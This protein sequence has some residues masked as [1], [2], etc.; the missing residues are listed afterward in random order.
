MNTE[1][2]TQ[3]SPIETQVIGSVK[4]FNNRY[5][6]GFIVATGEHSTYGDVFVHHSELQLSD[7]NVYKFLMPGEYVQFNIAKTVNGKHEFQATGVTGVN[8]GKLMCENQPSTHHRQPRRVDEDLRPRHQP[9]SSKPN[10][11]EQSRESRPPRRPRQESQAPSTASNESDGFIFPRGRKPPQQRS[12]SA[13]APA[14]S[15]YKNAITK[16]TQNKN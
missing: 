3:T 4:W 5:G 15:P 16:K 11:Q 10:S 14:P 7:S 2:S 1:I 12:S 13:S 8:G 6:Y 9:E